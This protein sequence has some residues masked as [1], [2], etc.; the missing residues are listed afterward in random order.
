MLQHNSDLLLGVRENHGAA[1]VVENRGESRA[2]LNL[3]GLAIASRCSGLKLVRVASNS[4]GLS[5]VDRV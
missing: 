1:D 3:S 2:G 4:V 5:E